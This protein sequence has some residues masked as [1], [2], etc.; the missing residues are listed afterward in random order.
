MWTLLNGFR[1]IPPTFTVIHVVCKFIRHLHPLRHFRTKSRSET[2]TSFLKVVKSGSSQSLRGIRGYKH[3]GGKDFNDVMFHSHSATGFV[4]EFCTRYQVNVINHFVSPW[5]VILLNLTI[6][7][8]PHPPLSVLDCIW[9]KY[10]R[11]CE[12]LSARPASKICCFQPK[13]IQASLEIQFEDS[14]VFHRHAFTCGS[15]QGHFS[16][17]VSVLPLIQNEINKQTS[18][19]Q[20]FWC[21]V[22]LLKFHSLSVLFFH[23]FTAV[24]YLFTETCSLA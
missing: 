8:I 1:N 19:S 6:L 5:C 23:T 9:R 16:D 18:T 2:K 7:P 4:F 22:L 11:C 15:S 24:Q 10:W 14:L 12:L 17:L 21:A 13:P 3:P 20:L